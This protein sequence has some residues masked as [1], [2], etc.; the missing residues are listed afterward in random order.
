MSEVFIC[1]NGHRNAQ[2]GHQISG[3]FL[4]LLPKDR[5][6]YECATEGCHA[7]AEPVSES[8]AIAV[9]GEGVHGVA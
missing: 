3:V 1:I 6:A 2:T 7:E 9:V 5:F 4:S 8:E